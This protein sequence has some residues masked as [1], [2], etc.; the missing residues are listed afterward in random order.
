MTERK[1]DHGTFAVTT[2]GDY[3]RLPNQLGN[4]LRLTNLSGK[5]AGI[6]NRHSTHVIDDFELGFDG[7]DVRSGKFG[8]MSGVDI[9]GRNSGELAGRIAKQLPI[10]LDDGYI[11]Q[12]SIHSLHGEIKVGL[13]D[14]LSRTDLMSSGT[15]GT[16]ISFSGGSIS[17]SAP[18]NSTAKWS[19]DKTYVLSIEVHPTLEKFTAEL[20]DGITTQVIAQGLDST[21]DLGEG[22]G[23]RA[24]GENYFLGI[25]AT[26]AVIDEVLYLKKES[27]PHEMI[28]NG[29]SYTFDCDSN[30]N[31][32]EI[33]NLG[34]DARDFSDN[35]ES[36]T[37]T[38]YYSNE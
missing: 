27:Y 19:E 37:L 7:W 6:R 3:N 36:I 33:I 34:S 31:E 2:N 23:V 26:S 1:R 24:S 13:F 32:Y 25:E 9:S 29:S 14:A 17:T 35:A 18:S 10:A 12:L 11:I 30:I 28:P 20:F 16:T 22:G 38:G 5:I 21:N 15:A 4:Q 8:R